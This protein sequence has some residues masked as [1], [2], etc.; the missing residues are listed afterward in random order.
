M[1][2]L[3]IFLSLLIILVVSLFLKIE[4]KHTL[5]ILIIST[6]ILF[7]MC[8]QENKLEDSKLSVININIHKMNNAIK[9]MNNNLGNQDNNFGNQVNNLGNQD[10]NFGNQVNNLGNQDNNLQ[11][12]SCKKMTTEDNIIEPCM[13]NQLDCTTDMSCILQPDNHNLFPGFGKE[14]KVKDKKTSLK[15]ECKVNKEEGIV[16]ENFI[17][18]TNPFQMNDVSV[19]FNSTIVDPYEH[20]KMIKNE[21]LEN[22]DKCSEVVGNDLCFHCRKGHCLGG[23]CRNIF[24]PKP[25]KMFKKNILINTHPYSEN[26]PVIRASNPDYSI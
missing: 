15:K 1:D 4:L 6:I 5:V 9:H 2:I 24:E 18:S 10:N 25:G 21:N 8:I 19:P 12:Q 7:I 16:V 13:Y 20:Y 17:S 22:S 11:K 3:K 26:Q 23:S 14:F